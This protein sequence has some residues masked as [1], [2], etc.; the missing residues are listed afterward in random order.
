MLA[1]EPHPREVLQAG[2]PPG[3]LTSVGE[4]QDLV[5]ALGVQEFAVLD[6]TKEMAARQ[7]EDFV[8][9]VVMDQFGVA[10]LVMGHDQRLGA[11][12]QGDARRLREWGRTRGLEVISIDAVTVQGEGG[13]TVIVSS[14]AV[15]R[16]LAAGDVAWAAAMLGRR[17][18]FTGTV[19]RG[20]GRGAREL[21]YPT[22]NLVPADPEKLLPA[23][24][25]YA[26]RASFDG[27]TWPGVLNLGRRPTFGGGPTCIEVHVPGLSGSLYRTRLCVSFEAWLR[28]ER[29][30][31]NPVELGEQIARDVRAALEVIGRNK[32]QGQEEEACPSPQ[33]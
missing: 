25:V 13:A 16:A 20:E 10:S 27:R 4:K 7:A 22:A 8:K 2:E 19:V 28:E 31:R 5:Q 11:G 12:R 23:A 29:R 14:T 30:F 6:F 1:L 33:T 15:R 17:Y 3:R 18:S 9:D 26:V 21:G 32:R 24:G